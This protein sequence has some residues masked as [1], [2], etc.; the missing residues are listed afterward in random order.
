[1]LL[2]ASKR[3]GSTKRGYN[4]LVL[5]HTRVHARG[6]AMLV[7]EMGAQPPVSIHL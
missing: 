1:M 7:L 3:G 6:W 5:K 2:A 4:K